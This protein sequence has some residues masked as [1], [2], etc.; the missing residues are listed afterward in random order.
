MKLSDLI[1]KAQSY[2]H[3]NVNLHEKSLDRAE[4]KEAIEKVRAEFNILK[5]LFK[6]LKEVYGTGE[7]GENAIDVD[8]IIE[9]LDNELSEKI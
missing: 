5:K 7:D 1:V 3:G 6:D 2:A 8:N 4:M 9:T